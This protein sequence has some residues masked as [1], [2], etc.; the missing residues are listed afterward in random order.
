VAQEM[1]VGT[2]EFI[3]TAKFVLTARFL[4]MLKKE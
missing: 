1:V 2:R 4:A 3:K